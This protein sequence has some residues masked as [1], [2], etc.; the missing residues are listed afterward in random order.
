MAEVDVLFVSSLAILPHQVL[1]L[2]ILNPYSQH[3]LT[4]TRDILSPLTVTLH[5]SIEPPVD[6][7]KN[8]FDALF[9]QL[10]FFDLLGCFDYTSNGLIPTEGPEGPGPVGLDWGI[11]SGSHFYY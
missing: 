8:F 7:D 5:P 6:I 4:Q 10:R 2:M 11:N 1:T 3:P 9:A